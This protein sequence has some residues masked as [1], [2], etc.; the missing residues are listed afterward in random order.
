[1]GDGEGFCMILPICCR[2]KGPSL[3]NYHI[4]HLQITVMFANLYVDILSLYCDISS[5]LFITMVVYLRRLSY[6]L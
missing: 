5:F 2:N 3:Q 1:M 4:F 6:G